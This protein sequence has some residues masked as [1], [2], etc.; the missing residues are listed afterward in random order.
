MKFIREPQK[1]IPVIYECDLAVV[2]G[3]CTGLFAAV[4][5][6]RL[7][8]RVALVEASGRLGGVAGNGLVNIWHSLYDIYDKRQIIA[9]LTEEM[10]SRMVAHGDAVVSKSESSAIRFNS[11]VLCCELD[12]LA[13]EN[14]IK[15]FL[16]TYYASLIK[17]SGKV[18]AILVENKD[19]RGAIRASFFID[20][21]G[22]GDLCRDVGLAAYRRDCLQ[23]PS[24]CFMIQ[25]KNKLNL[26]KLM[27]EHGEEFGLEEDWGWGG[28]IPGIDGI[29]FRADFHTYG[30]D[31]SKADDLTFAETDGRRKALMLTRLLQKYGSKDTRLVALCPMVGIRE[32]AHYP[33]RFRADE[34]NL[35]CGTTYEDT[36]MRGSYR[37][38]I[39]HSND[40]GITFKYLDG[41]QVSVYGRSGRKDE[42]SW[43]G[44]YGLIDAPAAH[45]EVPFGILV[46]DA[47]SNLI[48]AGRM[49]HADEG[50][51]GALRVM[52]N[53]N[54][55]GEAAGTAAYL[56]LD[57]GKTIGDLDGRAVRKLLV[58]GG[59]ALE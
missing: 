51:F 30:V 31:C 44:D 27:H 26:N 39:H 34:K 47:V 5:A 49:L 53:L 18:D 35:L 21:T 36:V 54:Q 41:R 6:A 55:L 17:E 10:V 52:V 56:A 20:A 32:T 2:G 25:D 45:Y 8:L 24:A 59:S 57:G 37:V 15:L 3:S 50:A 14:G 22:D 58:K 46:Q 33:A 29:R 12:A 42:G 13:K 23:P 16:H 11:A 19:G 9:G 4:R 38:D 28:D 7:G 40:G 48:P 43:L 1:Q